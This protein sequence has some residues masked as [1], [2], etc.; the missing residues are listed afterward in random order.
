MVGS[1]VSLILRFLLMCL[2]DDVVAV[3]CGIG[4]GCG[5][6]VRMIGS[7]V[8]SSLWLG[9]EA[10]AES[11]GCSGVSVGCPSVSVGCSGVSGDVG[12]LSLGFLLASCS[13]ATTFLRWLVYR[14]RYCCQ[15]SGLASSPCSSGT[16]CISDFHTV[17]GNAYRG[18][19][20]RPSI[21][22]E[23]VV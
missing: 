2:S 10:V 5:V 15:S 21:A 13:Y 20:K 1:G 12:T 23:V 11:V 19:S 8:G 6:L 4:S 22:N 18:K 14:G 17:I 7:V 3:C 9:G 16:S